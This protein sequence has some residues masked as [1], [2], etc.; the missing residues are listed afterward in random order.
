MTSP[1]TVK[2]ILFSTLLNCQYKCHTKYTFEFGGSFVTRCD[3][4]ITFGTRAIVK[5]LRINKLVGN[6]A[7]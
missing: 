5:R 6:I 7:Q 2:Q 3:E 1:L 4:L